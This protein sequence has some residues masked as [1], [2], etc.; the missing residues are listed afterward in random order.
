MATKPGRMVTYHEELLPI[1]VLNLLVTKFCEVT[2]Q[3]EHISTAILLMTT[4]LGKLV[5]YYEEVPPIKSHNPL[6]MWPYKIT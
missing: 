4:K 2:W 5:T 1:A 6:I 3:T